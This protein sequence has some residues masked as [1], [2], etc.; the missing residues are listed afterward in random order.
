MERPEININDYRSG[1]S[2]RLLNKKMQADGI[3]DT[4]RNLYPWCTPKTA[5]LVYCYEN[6]LENPPLCKTCGG[7]VKIP[8]ANYCSRK[9]TGTDPEIRKKCVDA[10]SKA[11]SN[12]E[13][14]NKGMK[15]ADTSWHAKYS[16]PETWEDAKKSLSEAN[17]GEKNG[18]YNWVERMPEM[19]LRQS[20]VM[21]NKILRGEFTPNTNNRKTHFDVSFDGRVYRSSWEAVYKQMNPEC[22]YET[23][24]IPYIN[25]SGESKVYIADFYN[26]KT[27][28]IIEIRPDELYDET[29]NKFKYAKEYCKTNGLAF[30]HVGIDYFVEH[31]NM[32]DYDVL[33]SDISRRIRNAI[34]KRKRN[35]K[36]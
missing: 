18:M 8:T 17:S 4:L 26:P 15:H 29:S 22:E 25:E 36:A 33:G 13:P 6:H 2:G 31:E 12:R 5:L 14:W 1:V 19:R 27:K 11:N 10:A 16:S 24:R 9:C 21:K 34:E 35:T 23:I 30:V 3:I 28:S 32:I 20:E 7:P